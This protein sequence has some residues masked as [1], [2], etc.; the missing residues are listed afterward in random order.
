MTESKAPKRSKLPLHWKILIGLVLGVVVGVVINTQWDAQTWQSFGVGDAGAYLS[1]SADRSAS[2]VEGGPN[3]DAGFGASAVRF[4]RDLNLFVG[5]LF[6]KMLRFIAVPL[7]LFSLI[8][9]TASLNDTAKL[10]RIG[11]K[12]IAIYLSTTAISITIGLLLANIVAPGAS[13][14]EE[15]RIELQAQG[16]D[17]AASKIQAAEGKPGMWDVLLDAVPSNPFAAMAETEM[18]QVVFA[19]LMIGIALTM[20]PKSKA[21]P[22]VAF[23]DGLTEAVIKVV[24]IVMLIAP[25]AVFALIVKVIAALGLDVLVSLINYSLVVL[26]GLLIMMLGVYPLI[27][28]LFTP[29]GYARFFKAIAPAQLLAFSSSS[30]SAT[31]PVTMECCEHR[32]GVKDEVSSFVLP[33]GATI[34]MDGTALYQGVS[35]VFIAQLWGIDLSIGDQITIVLTATLASIGTAA[36]PSAGVIMLVIVLQSVGLPMEGIAVIFGV[37]RI[38]DMCRTSCNVTGDAMVAAVVAQSEGQL[39]TEDELAASELQLVNE[40]PKAEDDRE[41]AYD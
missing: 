18:L 2:M 26:A 5:N 8:V 1:S 4:V 37:D 36:V 20:I 11:G 3:A 17:T 35:A 39:L 23:C 41:Q 30:S 12:T 7:V 33:L 9:G 14:P 27:L 32:L 19:A 25:Y 38:L 28:R 31:L 22:V 10:G 34:N 24:H 29:V 15:T 6:L 40:H 16:A 13:F 21:D